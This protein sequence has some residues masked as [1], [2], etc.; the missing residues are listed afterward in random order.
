MLL[1]L[2]AVC[3]HPAESN[4]ANRE[5]IINLF[6]MVLL[7]FACCVGCYSSCMASPSFSTS[8]PKPFAVLHPVPIRAKVVVMIRISAMR[9]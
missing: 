2:S 8:L 7:V 4:A 5:I 1:L 9:E 6:F 3:E